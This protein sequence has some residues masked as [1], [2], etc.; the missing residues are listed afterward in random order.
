MKQTILSLLFLLSALCTIAQQAD[1]TAKQRRLVFLGTSSGGLI[2]DA[3]DPQTDERY[4]FRHLNF[5]PRVGVFISQQLLL[6]A[7]GMMAY[8]WDSDNPVTANY[9]WGVIGRYYPKWAETFIKKTVSISTVYPFLELGYHRASYYQA[10]T[11]ITNTI[12]TLAP[13]LE[14]YLLPSPTIDEFQFAGGINWRLYKFIHLEVSA[15]YVYRPDEL[16]PPP[17]RFQA[18]VGFDFIFERKAG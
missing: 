14:Q 16:Y 10:D 6:A 4:H 12:G 17:S 18:R 7:Q 3:R 1:T 9:G 13:L 2:V 8:T 11:T 5:Q 15:V